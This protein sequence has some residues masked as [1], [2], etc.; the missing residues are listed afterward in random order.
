MCGIVERQ[1][2]WNSAILGLRDGD[3]VV[4]W[5]VEHIKDKVNRISLRVSK[6]F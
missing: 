1:E 3:V 2:P 4:G 5:E 6:K